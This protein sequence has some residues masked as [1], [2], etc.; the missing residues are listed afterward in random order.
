[1][2]A[3]THHRSNGTAALGHAVD[4]GHLH[5]APRRKAGRGQKVGRQDSAL[6]ADTAQKHGF[7]LVVHHWPPLFRNDRVEAAVLDALAAADAQGRVD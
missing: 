4:F 2:L 5:V 6:A 7:C 3:H 1:M